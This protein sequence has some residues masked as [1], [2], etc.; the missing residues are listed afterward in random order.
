[1]VT[2]STRSDGGAVDVVMYVTIRLVRA[3]S[4]VDK[5]TEVQ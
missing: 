1:M 5:V 3:S 4:E 2:V